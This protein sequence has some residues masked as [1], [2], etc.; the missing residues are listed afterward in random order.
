MICKYE[1]HECSFL[2]TNKQ[3]QLYVTKYTCL[4]SFKV[5]E[6][7]Q[8]IMSSDAKEKYPFQ[9]KKINKLLFDYHI[10]VSIINVTVI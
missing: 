3:T 5:T 10:H 4:I 2:L 1:D 6:I 9:N 8:A 7:E